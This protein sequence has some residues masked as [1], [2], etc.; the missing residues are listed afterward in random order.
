[1]GIRPMTEPPQ[2]NQKEIEHLCDHRK[3]QNPDVTV[4]TC[5]QAESTSVLNVIDA[6]V[7]FV[8]DMDFF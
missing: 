7:A 6:L 8:A 2:K 1:M 3:E 5:I 4:I